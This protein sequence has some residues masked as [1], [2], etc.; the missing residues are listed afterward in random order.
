MYS[1]SIERSGE[2][3]LDMIPVRFTNE[4][5][6]SEGAMYD[7]VSRKLFR[8]QGTGSFATGPDVAVPVMGLHFMRRP[9]YTAAS[10]YVQDGLVAMWDG[11]ENAGWGVH[12][13][14]AT[15]WKDLVGNLDA[16][17]SASPKW[18]DTSFIGD[19]T[20]AFLADG[21]SL[22]PVIANG[23]YSI[24]VRIGEPRV[25]A[26][27]GGY[28]SFGNVGSGATASTGIFIKG[29]MGTNTAYN[30]SVNGGSYGRNGTM[31]GRQSFSIA[32]NE[33]SFS[34]Y[35]D[36]VYTGTKTATCA[37]APPN[38]NLYLGRYY[39]SFGYSQSDIQSVRIYSRALSADEIAHNYA[40]DKERFNLP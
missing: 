23:R 25:A 37:F 8:N 21:S 17:A 40:V 39:Y 7:R 1:L 14:N 24:E 12:D 20:V 19:R 16:T 34:N 15:V 31:T 6:Q 10:D 22:L 32:A 2:K 28:F 29:N 35:I 3:V 18:T 27:E 33:T 11:I 5:G 36:G 26:N 38:A 30:A 4:L 9:R 13:P